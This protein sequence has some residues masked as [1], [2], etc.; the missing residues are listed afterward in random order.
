MYKWYV[1][2]LIIELS[3]IRL[4]FALR[5][6]TPYLTLPTC[7]SE[8]VGGYMPSLSFISLYIPFFGV[9]PISVFPII[10]VAR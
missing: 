1:I 4:L 9:F 10:K 3:C 5:T 7:R 6:S 8:D 2:I